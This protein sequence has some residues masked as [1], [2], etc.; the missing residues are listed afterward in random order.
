MFN[1]FGITLTIFT[2]LESIISLPSIAAEFRSID[3]SKNNLHQIDWGKADTLLLRFTSPDYDDGLSLFKQTGNSGNV[4][5]SPRQ[6][7]NAVSAQSQSV[8][9]YVGASDWLWQWGQFLDHDLSLTDIGRTE[10][11][12]ISVPQG[13]AFHTGNA[14]IGFHQSSSFG[15]DNKVVRQQHN[16]ITAYIE[17]SNVYGSDATRAKSLRTLDGT[18]QLKTS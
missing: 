13:D 16:D 15:V 8:E 12:N 9:N 6:I 5:P 3:G 14:T 10:K 7:S 4:L 2:I 18:G 11:F 1:K 17:A